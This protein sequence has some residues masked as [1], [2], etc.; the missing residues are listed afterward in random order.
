MTAPYPEGLGFAG[1]DVKAASA[2]VI[3]AGTDMIMKVVGELSAADLALA[4]LDAAV[5]RVLTARV[6]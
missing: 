1:G 2:Q 4:E 6:R 3:K 5:R